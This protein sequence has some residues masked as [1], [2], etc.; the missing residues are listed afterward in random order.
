MKVRGR[1]FIALVVLGPVMLGAAG[2][3]GSASTRPHQ[4]AAHATTDRK[5]VLTKRG[6]PNLAGLTIPLAT[7]A[8]HAGAEDTLGYIVT[9][10]LKQWGA[11]SS[12]TL[13]SSPTG[14]EA[15]LS[16]SIDAANSDMPTIINLPLEIFMANQSH[17]DYVF[18]SR[19]FT[20]LKQMKGKV[21]G[22]GSTTSPDYY[23]MPALLK[24][25]GLSASEISYISAGGGG[26][27]ALATLLATGRV[28]AAWIHVSNLTKVRTSQPNLVVLARAA[29]L[30]PTIADSWW[31]ARP[32]WLSS[33]P[34]VAEAICLAYIHAVKIFN[35]Q[36]T[37]WENYAEGYTTNADPLSAVAAE[38]KAFSYP[39]LWPFSQANLSPSVIQKNYTFYKNAGD[40]N[41][42]GI[43]PLKQVADYGPWTAAWKVYQAHQRAY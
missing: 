40:I 36:P 2:S 20:S 34:A 33:H 9:Q 5:L 31:G 17:Q 38:R 25:A 1:L 32:S 4:A 41:G 24:K 28:D 16:G 8:G 39:D 21:I 26:S 30:L 11:N 19:D 23:I 15:V 27:S 35:T 12:L 43:R 29:T 3:P 18:A 42:A 7:S 13:G 6:V 10:T 22:I 37:T 14:E